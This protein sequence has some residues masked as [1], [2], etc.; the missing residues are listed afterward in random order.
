M[1]DNYNADVLRLTNSNH[2][3]TPEGFRI[4]N[5]QEDSDL[6]AAAIN[7]AIRNGQDVLLSER[8][9]S[10]ADI[11]VTESGKTRILGSGATLQIP[12]GRF[13]ALHCT[14]EVDLTIEGV[15]FIGG[16]TPSSTITETP[17]PDLLS[18][19][20]GGSLTVRK[21]AFSNVRTSSFNAQAGAT[22]PRMQYVD[23]R[24]YLI[25]GVGLARFVFEENEI[26]DC[27]GEEIMWICPT[28]SRNDTLISFC[29]NNVHDV[30]GWSF[31]LFGK[32]ISV[33]GNGIRGYRKNSSIFNLCCEFA[34]VRDNA[35]S[36]SAARDV[37]D[38]CEQGAFYGRR[39]TVE[40][41]NVEAAG[42]GLVRTCGSSAVIR[43]N[44]VYGSWLALHYTAK[45]PLSLRTKS[46]VCMIAEDWITSERYLL[47]DNHFVFRKAPDSGFPYEYTVRI[48]TPGNFLVPADYDPTIPESATFAD[49]TEAQKDLVDAARMRIAPAEEVAVQ[50]NTFDMSEDRNYA[51]GDRPADGLVQCYEAKKLTFAGNTILAPRRD[52]GFSAAYHALLYLLPYKDGFGIVNFSDNTTR[53]AADP[54]PG[55]AYTVFYPVFPALL[56]GNRPY[57]FIRDLTL[58]GNEWRSHTGEKQTVYVGLLLNAG[59]EPLSRIGTVAYTED[60]LMQGGSVFG[61]LANARDADV[62]ISETILRERLG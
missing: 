13:N 29:R 40:N 17:Y 48:G 31:N 22:Y 41:N 51:G 21:C 28:G 30:E 58:R 34:D 1:T 54:A 23:R 52:H 60:L 50:N 45:T 62:V 9:Y 33:C 18:M 24:G 19:P 32:T 26:F 16:N 53:Y 10:V 57:W 35:V 6:L 3:V 4:S 2:Y 12:A 36:D 20:N 15:R 7:A 59:E 11:A 14:G 37:F 27:G 56:P 43:G 42:G 38:F 61:G 39:V 47:T 25:S 46:P 44:T 5:D 49:L 8:I 55:S